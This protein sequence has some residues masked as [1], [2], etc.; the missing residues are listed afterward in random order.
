[1]EYNNI[2]SYESLVLYIVYYI[3]YIL[4]IIKIYNSLSI[5]LFYFN[6][7]NNDEIIINY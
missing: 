6:E 5:V 4:Y 1:M 7:F 2:I 3:N